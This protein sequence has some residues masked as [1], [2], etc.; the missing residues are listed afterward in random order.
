MGDGILPH[1]IPHWYSE[2]MTKQIAVRLPEDL[3]KFIDTLVTEGE[4]PSR[5][6]V[7]ARALAHEQRRMRIAKD[8]EILSG[9]R[10]ADDFDELAEYSARQPIDLD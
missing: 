5:A 1:C 8:V 6:A 2:V 3:V 4:V 10:V 7:V 9:S